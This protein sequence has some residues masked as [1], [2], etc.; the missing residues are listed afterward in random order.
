MKLVKALGA[1]GCLTAASA[2]ARKGVPAWDADVFR[3]VNSLP[4]ALAPVAWLPMQAGALGAPLAIGAVVFLKWDRRSG[5]RMALTG[6]AAWSAA[7]VLKKE[8][9]RGRPGEFV[10][11]TLRFGSADRGLGFPSGHAAVVATLVAS[12]PSDAHPMVKAG[13]VA[14]ATTVGLARIHVGAHF[15]LDVIGGWAMGASIAAI[16]DEIPGGTTKPRLA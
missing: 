5:A 10:Q 14:L 9:G 12:I 8:I 4:D 13:G 7:K 16:Y 1:L 3:R 2:M 11:S 6:L 15:P